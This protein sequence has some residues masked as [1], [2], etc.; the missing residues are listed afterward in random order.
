MKKI[1]S[2]LS[3]MTVCV[4]AGHNSA[5]ALNPLLGLS[6][7]T[8]ALTAY[9]TD[10]ICAMNDY[11]IGKKVGGCTLEQVG[12]A[13]TGNGFDKHGGSGHVCAKFHDGSTN[14]VAKA[15]E[16]G[17]VMPLV[18]DSTAK[19]KAGEDARILG[20]CYTEQLA[21]ESCEHNCDDATCN[22]N[23]G[24]KCVPKYI[25]YSEA[26]AMLRKNAIELIGGKAFAGCYCDKA[27]PEPEPEPE[28]PNLCTCPEDGECV[29]NGTVD[30]KCNGRVS[31]TIEVEVGCVNY[32]TEEDIA[33][34]IA[35]KYATDIENFKCDDT[36][37]VKADVVSDNNKKMSSG[38]SAWVVKQVEADESVADEQKKTAEKSSK[39]QS[40]Q[41]KKQ[42]AKQDNTKKNKEIIAAHD[43]LKEFF[44]KVDSDKSVWKNAD[45]SFNTIRLASDLTAGVVLGT[46]GGVVSGV[47]IKKSQV[48][49]GFD[50]LHCTVGGQ[51]IADWGDEFTVGLRR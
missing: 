20:Y 27:E 41:D 9:M 32:D 8:S 7:L 19:A 45:G 13:C 16:A 26:N 17:Y 4:V 28:L 36:K 48:E 1:V 31:K 2:I 44:N 38:A 34:K 51:K 23:K 29:F 30:L 33:K 42:E 14:C 46:V 50:A 24:D 6:A 39:Q 11:N 35:E 47:L 12:K 5:Y 10:E 25:S 22:S 40:K 18:F 21:K 49:K 15:C 3:V 37:D 43:N